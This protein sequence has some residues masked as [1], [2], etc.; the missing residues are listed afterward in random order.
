MTTKVDFSGLQQYDSLAA[1]KAVPTAGGLLPDTSTGSTW[2]FVQFVNVVGGGPGAPGSD[3]AIIG[4]VLYRWDGASTSASREPY[5]VRPDDFVTDGVGVWKS[6]ES[7]QL[8]LAENAFAGRLKVSLS[9]DFVVA[10][11]VATQTPTIPTMG[12]VGIES[13]PTGGFAASISGG[14]VDGIITLVDNAE[15]TRADANGL[16]VTGTLSVNG[17][18]VTGGTALQVLDDATPINSDVSKINFTGAA[19]VTQ[20]IIDAGQV[21]VNVT[22]GA[23]TPLAVDENDVEVNGDVT[24]LNFASGATVTQDGGDAG[25]VNIVV[26]P[27][28]SDLFA[29]TDVT[30]TPTDPT[31]GWETPGEV[32]APITGFAGA[33]QAGVT[34][35]IV[36]LINNNEVGRWEDG[37]LEVDDEL[38]VIGVNPEIHLYDTNGTVGKRRYVMKPLVGDDEKLA[39][40]PANDGGGES[41]PAFM[42]MDS[43]TQVVDFTQT[44]TVNDVPVGDMLKSEYVY[45]DAVFSHPTDL[46]EASYS[47][48]VSA[49]QQSATPIPVGTFV[50]VNIVQTAQ[51]VVVYPADSTVG[52]IA[53]AV[54]IEEIPPFN[55][56]ADAGKIVYLGMSVG[57]YQGV[58]GFYIGSKVYLGAN[59][60]ASTVPDPLSP[61]RLGTV[62]GQGGNLSGTVKFAPFAEAGMADAVPLWRYRDA[63]SG[64]PSN[65]TVSY[66]VGDKVLDD[67]GTVSESDTTLGVATNPNGIRILVCHTLHTATSSLTADIGNWSTVSDC[68]TALAVTA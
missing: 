53:G 52:D 58:S 30:N 42:A 26:T 15:V 63:T 16:D 65:T 27:G 62:F 47:N 14:S 20:D 57:T 5:I 66:L 7:A 56:G 44:P 40:Y 41:N 34:E 31:I 35:A 36:A 25:T 29:D 11:N 43:T 59:G 22:G 48:A 33:S 50:T 60:V 23:G 45:T 61:Q 39:I 38:H 49:I 1:L 6:I 12:L 18:P 68:P 9:G 10:T 3:D 21:N 13:D 4:N 55:N 46:L 37:L 51:T 64:S 2:A 67:G 19:D 54:V 8:N 24:T 28:A 17:S 32:G